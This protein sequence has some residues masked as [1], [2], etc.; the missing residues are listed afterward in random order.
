MWMTA[1][2]SGCLHGLLYLAAV[3]RSSRYRSSRPALVAVPA[4]SEPVAPVP[5]APVAVPDVACVASFYLSRACLSGVVAGAAG[6]VV[7]LAHEPVEYPSKL[8]MNGELPI[9][10]PDFHLPV[11][12]A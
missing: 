9:A 10:A 1:E 3:Q 6:R 11:G 8:D 12:P 7:D 4:A 5:V 2:C